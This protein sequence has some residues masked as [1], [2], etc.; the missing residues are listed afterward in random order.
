MKKGH[1]SGSVVRSVEVSLAGLP[2]TPFVLGAEFTPQRLVLRVNE[3][4]RK[5]ADSFE[6][7]ESRP[8]EGLTVGFDGGESSVGPAAAS[9]PFAGEI[10]E[11]R[12]RLVE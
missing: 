10:D 9:E 12:I 6:H 5:T 3:Q 1:Y 11:V 2:T 7:F 4:I 8:K